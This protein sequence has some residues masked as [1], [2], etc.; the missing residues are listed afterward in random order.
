M[1][2]LLTYFTAIL[3]RVDYCSL[4]PS[5]FNVTILCDNLNPISVIFIIPQSK[6]KDTI[7]RHSNSNLECTFGLVVCG[8]G[9]SPSFIYKYTLSV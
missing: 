9:S 6:Y 8:L 2:T 5:S 3:D 7:S 1:K 4:T